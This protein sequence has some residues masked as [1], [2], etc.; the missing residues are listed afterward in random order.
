M[1]LFLELSSILLI[2]VALFAVQRDGNVLMAA[3]WL[4]MGVRA[5]VLA[6]DDDGDEGNV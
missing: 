5:L 1:R 6:M 3:G 4:Y 2:A